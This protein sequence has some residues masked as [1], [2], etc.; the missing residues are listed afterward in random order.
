MRCSAASCIRPIWSESALRHLLLAAQECE[1]DIDLHVDEELNAAG[2]RP[3]HHRPHRCARSASKAASS[4]AISARWRPSPRRRRWPRSTRWRARRSPWSRCPP[5]T[6][7]C[8]TPSPV[9]RRACA[10]SRWSR[11]RA[12]AAFRCCS[13]A[14]TC[15]TRSAGSAASTRSRRWAP[16]RWPRSS[17][18][19]SIPGRKALCRS[20]WL[21]RGTARRRAP[22]LVG[23][24]ADLVLFTDADV[25]G[26]PSRA[27]GARGAAR[28]RLRARHDPAF[29]S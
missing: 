26:W 28:R 1:L 22:T 11:K 18:S 17:T 14:T 3:R 16:R 13:R 8:R 5:P 20:D 24:A 21:Q 15:R 6:C 2:G 29:F 12:S 10:A 25:H 27:A 9:A 23:A 7:C 4:A 19:P